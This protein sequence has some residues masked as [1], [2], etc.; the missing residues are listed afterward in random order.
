M[1]FVT[2]KTR[3]KFIV[4]FDESVNDFIGISVCSVPQHFKIHFCRIGSLDF[5]MDTI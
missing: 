1:G 3:S 4:D 2:D 5:V